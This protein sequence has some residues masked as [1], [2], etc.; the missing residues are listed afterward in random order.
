[1]TL[2]WK[3]GS[4]LKY[5]EPMCFTQYRC[6]K[7]LITMELMHQYLPW[8]AGIWSARVLQGCSAEDILQLHGNTWSSLTQKVEKLDAQKEQIQDNLWLKAQKQN[9]KSGIPDVNKLR[10]SEATYLNE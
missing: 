10:Q 3:S 6:G 4:L 7:I 2:V 5:T 8:F 1:M 9:L